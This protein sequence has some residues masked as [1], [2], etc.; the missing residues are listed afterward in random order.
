M[1]FDVHQCG[2]TMLHVASVGDP[3][4][5]LIVCLHGFPEFWAAWEPV[6]A[7]LSG[8]FHV[9]VP[10]QR[11]YNLSSKPKGVDAYRA[12]KLVADLAALA[13]RLSPGKPFVLAGHDW[14][15]S[16]AYAFAFAHPDRLTHLVIANGVHPV[17][18]QRAILDDPDQRQASQYINRL[19]SAGQ[20]ARMAEN[21]FSRTFRM[22]S[23]F[24]ATP[25]MTKAMQ[26]RYLDAWSRPGAMEAML[27]WYRASPIVV[28]PPGAEVASAPVLGIDPQA[29]TVRV[30]HLL[31]WG[32]DDEALRP[33]C[34]EGLERFVPD[35]TVKHIQRTG[36]WLLH[37][38]PAEVAAMM[39]DF[40]R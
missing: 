20:E 36:H 17:C 1:R 39:R 15:A 23:G 31:I 18:F 28:P 3:A 26:A 27:N 34:F 22:I 37:E 19:T 32:D 29:V 24:S 14:G 35:L 40:V 2:E 8:D 12:R 11:G 33:S 30:P 13:D 6:M 38:K 21:D 7:E 16:V 25:W 10:D 5:P 9:V 4:K